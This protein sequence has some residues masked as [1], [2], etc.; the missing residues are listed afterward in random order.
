MR[1]LSLPTIARLRSEDELVYTPK[2]GRPFRAP[3]ERTLLKTRAQYLT[4]K[5]E[6]MHHKL[7]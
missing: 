6:N 2:M 7:K 1:S 3:G 5:F 4:M